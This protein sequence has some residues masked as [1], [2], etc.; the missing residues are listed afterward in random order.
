M[1]IAQNPG[2]IRGCVFRVKS[3]VSTLSIYMP[4][5]TVI[6]RVLLKKGEVGS[7]WDALFLVKLVIFQLKLSKFFEFQVSS[8]TFKIQLLV[9]QLT[10]SNFNYF[11]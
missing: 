8:V 7:F 6:E 2:E 10:G 5:F 9:L 4:N 1:L 3:W 11:L